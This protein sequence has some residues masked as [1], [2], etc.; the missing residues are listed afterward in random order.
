MIGAADTFTG[1]FACGLLRDSYKPAHALLTA[2]A[3]GA[4]ATE[5]KGARASMPGYTQVEDFLYTRGIKVAHGMNDAWPSVVDARLFEMQ[6]AVEKVHTENYHKNIFVHMR[7][8]V[9]VC[10][11]LFSIQHVLVSQICF[12]HTL[13]AFIFNPTY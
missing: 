7:V 2:V 11:C 4:M 10:V 13:C 12:V 1:A 3:A 9:C 8:C 5:Q 6:A